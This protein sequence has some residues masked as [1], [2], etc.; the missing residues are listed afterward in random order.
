MTQQHRLLGAARGDLVGEQV[1]LLG[2]LPGVEGRR[3]GR[4][5]RH[6][7]DEHALGAVGVDGEQYGVL[8]LGGAAHE[9]LPVAAPR[10]RADDACAEQGRDPLAQPLA[11]GH[12]L[13]GLGEQR[14][15]R[16]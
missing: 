8:L 2:R 16:R 15:L 11:A 9:E 7:V 6:R 14:V 12:V 1:A 13:D 4:V 3:A 10:R 5:E